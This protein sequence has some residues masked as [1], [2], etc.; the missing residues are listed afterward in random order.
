MAVRREEAMVPVDYVSNF[1]KNLRIFGKSVE[2][3]KTTFVGS[4]SAPMKPIVVNIGSY[5]QNMA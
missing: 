1:G 3:R 4:N 2:R 5:M